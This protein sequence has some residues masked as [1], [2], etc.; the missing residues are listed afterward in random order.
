LL[1]LKKE[2]GE[3]CKLMMLSCGASSREEA[4]ELIRLMEL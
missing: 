3:Q 1:A 2:F 4:E